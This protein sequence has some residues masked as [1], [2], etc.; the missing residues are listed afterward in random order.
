M[1]RPTLDHSFAFNQQDYVGLGVS[2]F[3]NTFFDVQVIKRN[4]KYAFKRM[5]SDSDELAPALF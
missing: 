5:L 4:K 3:Q 1:P 2:F